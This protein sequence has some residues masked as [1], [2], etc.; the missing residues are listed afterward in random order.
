MN[1]IYLLL[2]LLILFLGIFQLFYPKKF[3]E[4]VQKPMYKNPDAVMPSEKAFKLQR[5]IGL[6]FIVVSLVLLMK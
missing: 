2:P 1:I 3:W 4:R 6:I 5:F